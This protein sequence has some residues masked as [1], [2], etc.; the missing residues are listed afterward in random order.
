MTPSKD[1]P[2]AS[3][4]P[5]Q[6][7]LAMRRAGI[8]DADGN[9]RWPFNDQEY[10][11]MDTQPFD[12]TLAEQGARLVT[13]KGLNV[14]FI[15]RDSV[16]GK[17]AVMVETYENAWTID[18]NG[19][20]PGFGEVRVV[21]EHDD[22][23]ED[24]PAPSF[25]QVFQDSMAKARTQMNDLV[26][27]VAGNGTTAAAATKAAGDVLQGLWQQVR[28]AFPSKDPD[29]E[30]GIPHDQVMR[31]MDDLINSPKTA[32]GE[33]WLADLSDYNYGND[34]KEVEIQQTLPTLP[35]TPYPIKVVYDGRPALWIDTSDLM[36]KLKDA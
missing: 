18:S 11:D 20:C 25:E 22:E 15:G 7:K 29:H 8:I 31:Q 32:V 26:A 33:V 1:N 12:L 2:Y 24:P 4:T 9:L 23:P 36:Y 6:S 34:Y 13:D 35:N 27:M 10:P 30:P 17:I 21:E 5:E 19:H 16:T 28:A 3:L 14:R